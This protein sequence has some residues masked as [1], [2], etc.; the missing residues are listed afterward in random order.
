MNGFS[1]K[2]PPHH[3]LKAMPKL[4][5]LRLIGILSFLTFFFLLAKPVT[6]DH[7]PDPHSKTRVK[8]IYVI[9]WFDT[10]DYILPQ[11]DD[12]AL[13]VAEILTQQGVRATFKIVGEKART[14][15]KR[16][17]QDVIAA[18]SRHDIGFHSNLH[19]QQPSPALRLRDM[20]WEEGVQEFDRTERE[21]GRASCRER[22]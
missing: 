20:G 3:W 7:L 21:I 8:T 22:V 9:L 18:L 6:S 2:I 14:L 1:L 12:A 17:R 15:E 4:T 5:F 11:S 10:E 13:R 16:G 19:S